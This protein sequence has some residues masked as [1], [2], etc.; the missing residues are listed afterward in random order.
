MY[1]ESCSKAAQNRAVFYWFGLKDG[2]IATGEPDTFMRN[3]G[4]NDDILP[5]LFCGNMIL[6]F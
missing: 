6:N 2:G 4:K 5:S 3:Y 1:T